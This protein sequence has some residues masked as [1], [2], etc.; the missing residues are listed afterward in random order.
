MVAWGKIRLDNRTAIKIENEIRQ[1]PRH[2]PEDRGETRIVSREL[3]KIAR[4][5]APEYFSRVS[6][7]K[8]NATCSQRRSMKSVR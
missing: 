1:F 2:E 3:P 8:E 6:A 5:F 4:A 7:D